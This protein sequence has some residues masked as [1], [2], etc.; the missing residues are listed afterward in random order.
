MHIKGTDVIRAS[1]S[2]RKALTHHAHTA[3]KNLKKRYTESKSQYK[4]KTSLWCTE[5]NHFIHEN[6]GGEGHSEGT[7][8]NFASDVVLGE[9]GPKMLF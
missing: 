5:Q 7:S 2:S 8:L 3:G 6:G 1:K 4:Q 9:P